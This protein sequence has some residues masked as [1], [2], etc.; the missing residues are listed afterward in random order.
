MSQKK[1]SSMSLTEVRE[2]KLK[3]LERNKRRLL[4]DL[5]FGAI[6]TVA[7]VQR[8]IG[9][10]IIDF[11]GEQPLT[12]QIISDIFDYR[13]A[14]IKAGELD[15]TSG[16]SIVDAPVT[17]ELIEEKETGVGIFDKPLEAFTKNPHVR[18][19]PFQDRAARKVLHKLVTENLPSVLLQAPVGSGKTFMYGA[20][21]RTLYEVGWKPLLDCFSPY[22]VTIITKATVVEQTIRVLTKNFGLELG[23][24]VDVTNID[25][26][27][28][29]FGETFIEEETVVSYGEAHIK[30]NWKPLMI[31]AL[32]ILDECQAVKNID[33]QQSKI[34]QALFDVAEEYRPRCIF[35]SATPFTRVI[36]AKC[37]VLSTGL[38]FV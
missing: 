36:E 22:P 14:K 1:L 31:P 16:V 4:S 12:R 6:H 5:K 9:W 15:G 7:D 28:S 20:I 34:I 26:L 38:E 21:I 33:S 29:K 3:E 27:R 30:Y 35:T 32:V 24:Q 13:A 10:T 18:S 37:F 17:P 2:V 19:L 25:Q 23:T 8:N 11:P